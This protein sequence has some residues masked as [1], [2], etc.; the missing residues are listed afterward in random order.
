MSGVEKRRIE[1]IL[2]AQPQDE[3][4]RALL[5]WRKR[6][7]ILPPNKAVMIPKTHRPQAKEYYRILRQA[8]RNLCVCELCGSDYHITV[9]HK[10]GNPHNNRLENL[11][12]VCWNCHLV[13]HDPTED[14][15]HDEREGTK[16][17]IESGEGFQ[18]EE[19]E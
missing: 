1:A 10:D 8:N 2:T 15:V 9:H 3:P 11:Q 5:K 19:E 6:T 7:W 16:A 12:V 4:D 17:D 18:M 13:Y 14:G